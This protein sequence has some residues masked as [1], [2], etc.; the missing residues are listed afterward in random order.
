MDFGENSGGAGVVVAKSS[1]V[2]PTGHFDN[3]PTAV[4]SSVLNLGANAAGSEK[5][6]RQGRG[7][8]GG[9]EERSLIKFE[10]LSL[11]LSQMRGLVICI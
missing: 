2:D 9:K 5:G 3:A 8:A 10:R 6:P 1:P 11:Y 4:L 7:A